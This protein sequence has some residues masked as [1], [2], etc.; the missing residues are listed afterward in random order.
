MSPQVLMMMAQSELLNILC[1]IHWDIG[2]ECHPTFSNI[3]ENIQLPI[4]GLKSKI[5]K[6]P[7][8]ADVKLGL[9]FSPDNGSKT[10]VLKH[11]AS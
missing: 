3:L 2:Y 11:Q 8:G 6:I 4:S 5:R 7:A 10:V 1:Y 9:L